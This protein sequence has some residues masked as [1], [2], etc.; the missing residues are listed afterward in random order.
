LFKDKQVIVL[1]KPTGLAVQGGSGQIK[2]LDGML[3][4]LRFDSSERPRLVHRL[5]QDTA[6]VLVLARSAEAARF[7]TAE[8]KGDGPRKIYWAL[9]AGVP[10]RPKGLID[11]PLGK[12]G[13]A[14]GEKMVV[15]APGAK[16]AQ[17]RYAV[18]ATKGKQAAW[19]ALRPLTGRTHQLRAHMAALGHPILG[20]GKYGGK[21][22]YLSRTVLPKIL[23]LQAHE[24]A[25]SH[26][27]DGTTLRVRAPLPPHF[28]T[29]FKALGLDP[30]SPLALRAADWLENPQG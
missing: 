1:N 8:F 28:V 18:V 16:S 6:G 2:H 23:M 26:P 11:L 24:I 13:G 7:L 15:A 12:A 10:E 27:E 5:D 25:I 17:T 9:V 21:T 14:G 29:A 30:D 22:A 20:D 3:D 19:L 4:A